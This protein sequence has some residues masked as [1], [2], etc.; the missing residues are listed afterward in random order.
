[1]NASSI[2][3]LNQFMQSKITFEDKLTQI[4]PLGTNLGFA[5]KENA[6]NLSAHN[7]R[8]IEEESLQ[9]H[10]EPISKNKYPSVE[11]APRQGELIETPQQK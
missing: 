5:P 10:N 9:E 3:N 6:D 1:M 7:S 11:D 2:A 8:G 4:K